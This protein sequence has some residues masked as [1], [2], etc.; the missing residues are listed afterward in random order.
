MICKDRSAKTLNNVFAKSAVQ[1]ELH[2]VSRKRLPCLKAGRTEK[3]S[4][5]KIFKELGSKPERRGYLGQRQEEATIWLYNNKNIL[6]SRKL[7]LQ[8]I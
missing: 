1:N 2:C 4:L 8:N 5:Q 3:E 7:Q 6:L